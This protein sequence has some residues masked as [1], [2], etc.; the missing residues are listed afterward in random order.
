[1]SSQANG[2]GQQASSGEGQQGDKVNQ[3]ADIDQRLKELE[4]S[5]QRLLSESK[6]W[7]EK[8]QTAAQQREAEERAKL[9]KE[10]DLKS[11][12][13]RVEQEKDQALKELSQTRGK[14]LRENIRTTLLK[15]APDVYD[16]DDLVN[17]PQFKDIL[18][19]G[20][21]KDKLELSTEQ[22]KVFAQKVK[23]SKPHL[24]KPT[25]GM[26]VNTDRPGSGAGT[27]GNGSQDFKAMESNALKEFLLKNF[28]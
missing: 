23:E 11:V 27:S 16:V 25:N 20:V 19:S 17:Q 13:Q 15:I 18:E 6:Q 24:F 14:V 21:D 5:N 3:T 8:Y 1:M 10:G 9:E 28:N 4:A 12:L 22:A 26:G 7:K 2:E